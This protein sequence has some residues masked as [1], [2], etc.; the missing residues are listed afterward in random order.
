MAEHECQH[1][2]YP[3]DK[4][5][6]GGSLTGEVDGEE[7]SIDSIHDLREFIRR[8]GEGGPEAA[9]SLLVDQQPSGEPYVLPQSDEEDSVERKKQSRT[10]SISGIGQGFDMGAY[11]DVLDRIETFYRFEQAKKVK[12]WMRASPQSQLHQEL[13]QRRQQAEQQIN[14]VLSN[15]SDLYEQKQL[16]EHDV[17]K[18]E[19]RKAH[20]EASEE[21]KK[22]G[23]GYED[24]LKADFVDLVDQH[25]G[26]SS[27]IQMQ[28]NNVFPSITADFYRMTGLDDLQEGGQLEDL[29][30]NEKAVLRKKWKLYEQWKEQF[31]TAV[32]SRLNDVQRRLNSVETSIEQTEKWIQPYV[33]DMQRILSES[34]LDEQIAVGEELSAYFP[35]AYS[36]SWRMM[37]FFSRRDRTPG[38]HRGLYWDVVT[39]N[40]IKLSTPQ[41]ENPQQAG[42]GLVIFKMQFTEITVCD[43]VWEEIYQPQIDKQVNQVRRY[44]RKYVGEPEVEL[45]E[46]RSDIQGTYGDALTDEEEERL[47]EAETVSELEQLELDIIDR[48]K[49][50]WLERRKRGLKEF[51][52]F[53]DEYYHEDPE[54]LRRELLGPHFPTQF[55]L[56]YKYEND[57]YVM[58]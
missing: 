42:G 50:S 36:N 52:G 9:E 49:P 23:G 3:V 8:K 24:E 6:H 28:A 21:E 51:L 44:I 43:H 7:F 31:R 39:L 15:L 26:R 18:L 25:T 38:D 35:H 11:L 48:M 58:K 14:R 57:L 33:Q 45:D 16:L 55:Y 30:E 56:D 27:I 22:A 1:G 40:P 37:K 10:I 46:K 29:P 19:E 2:C 54:E 20:F 17:R 5:W 47:E 53:T 41:F 32:E 13:V 34:D 12:D 4:R